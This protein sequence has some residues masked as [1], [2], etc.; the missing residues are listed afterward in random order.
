[1]TQPEEMTMLDSMNLPDD[2]SRSLA[3]ASGISELGAVLV[4]DGEGKFNLLKP[5]SNRLSRIAAAATLKPV[6]I[7]VIV[8]GKAC[9][10]CI[11]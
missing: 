7:K 3:E 4:F 6:C 1:M 11:P 9:V 5:A 8:G 2:I 10:L